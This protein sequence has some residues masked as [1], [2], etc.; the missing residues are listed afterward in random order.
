IPP[1]KWLSRL[2]LER[3]D[4]IAMHAIVALCKT[5]QA[6]AHS[7]IIADRLAKVAFG[8]NIETV[9]DMLRTWQLVF[10]H[11][12]V[13]RIRSHGSK[14]ADEAVKHFPNTDNAVSREL[15][16]L[17]TYARRSGLTSA[18]VH[19]MLLQAMLASTD[20]QQQIHY[21]YCLRLLH[22]DW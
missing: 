5:G 7:E 21:F 22:H 19:K 20:R 11:T 13:G 18:P 2:T 17:L 4:Y 10:L 16:I 1:E 14:F 15:A 12:G 6:K 8:D 3:S 9:L